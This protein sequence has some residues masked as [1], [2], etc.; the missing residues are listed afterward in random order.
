[1]MKPNG[2]ALNVPKKFFYS[3]PPTTQGEEISH[4]TKKQLTNE[5]KLINQLNDA[6]NHQIFQI[7]QHITVLINSVKVLSLIHS[8]ELTYF[9]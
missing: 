9:T 8:M 1:M 2:S 5:E 6:M 7:H 4:K 3:P